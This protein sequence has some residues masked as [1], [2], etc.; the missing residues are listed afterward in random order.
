VQRIFG[1]D[2]VRLDRPLDAVARGAAAFVAGAD[3]FDHVQ[4]DYALRV[5]DPLRGLP[6]YRPLV[7]RGT[8]Y[9]TREPVA[10][11]VIRATH[12]GQRQL[13]LAICELAQRPGG[14][15][16]EGVELVFDPSGAAR[17]VEV[18]A[19]ERERRERFWVNEQAPTFLS[20]DPPA[21]RG[22]ACFEVSFGI[23]ENKH[24][25]VTARDLRTGRLTHDRVP[26]V[27]LV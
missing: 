14:Q 22:E 4:H 5:V 15:S 17:L 18:Q 20:A 10:R 12:D 26:V 1:R 11:L 6:D 9:P 2:R 25:E 8:P 7:K 27:K 19:D 23:D 13:G 16:G 3:F 24:L 21:R